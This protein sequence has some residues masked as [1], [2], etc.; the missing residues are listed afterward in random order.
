MEFNGKILPEFMNVPD[1]LHENIQ[2]LWKII[3]HCISNK[4]SYNFHKTDFHFFP[5]VMQV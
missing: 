5:I 2:L 3:I 4:G 1:I